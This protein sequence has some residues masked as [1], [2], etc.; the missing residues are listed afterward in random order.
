M[1]LSPGEEAVIGLQLEQASGG[2]VGVLLI[3]DDGGPLQQELVHVG[4][5]GQRIPRNELSA[6]AKSPLGLLHALEVRLHF[7]LIR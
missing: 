7:G 5:D 1:D 2:L 3:V 6:V 4:P